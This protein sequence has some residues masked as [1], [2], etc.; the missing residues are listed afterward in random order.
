MADTHTTRPAAEDEDFIKAKYDFTAVYNDP[1]PRPL[2]RVYRELNYCVPYHIEHFI[3]ALVDMAGKARGA[4]RVRVVDVGCSYGINALLLKH[5]MGYRR[6][7]ATV[8]D[9]GLPD[10]DLPGMLAGR[11][12][13]QRPV[14]VIGFDVS[15]NAIDFCRRTGVQDRSVLA[16][17]ERRDVP[18]D[19]RDD[20]A[21]CDVVL[22]SGVY[23]YI[24]ERTMGRLVTASDNDRGV[25]WVCNFALTPIDYTPTAA[26]LREFGLVTETAPVLFPHRRFN[27]PVEREATLAFNRRAGSD[28]A[29]ERKTGYLYTRCYISRPAEFARRLPLEPFW[30]REIPRHLASR[31]LPDPLH[32]QWST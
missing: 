9:G 13:G 18:A 15:P 12:T 19:A 17:L 4:P 23:G 7:S 32:Q 30:S 24:S 5:R 16:D 3:A 11:A 26:L 21:G 14:D 10:A 31:L 20:V 2:M 8:L 6:L 22:S 1:S 25:P 29:A 27:S 28:S